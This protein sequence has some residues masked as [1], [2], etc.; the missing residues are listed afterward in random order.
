ME[1]PMSLS[2]LAAIGS[3]VSGVA[4]LI[5]LIYLALQIRQAA[6]NQRGT[7]HQMRA[8]LSTDVM[9][10]IAEPE[11]LPAFRAGLTGSPDISEAQFWQYY[12]AASAILRATE[13][14]FA[15][16]RDGLVSETHF[17]S[18]KASARSFLSY[19]GYR[20]LWQASRLGREAGFRDFMDSLEREVSVRPPP[21]LYQDWKSRLKDAAVQNEKAGLARS[22]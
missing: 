8:A 2:D 5:S 14:A 22:G 1:I 4:V 6:A 13:N 12:Y 20:A 19:P 18:A 15:Q 7:M 9:L 11:L 3:F 16:Y 10:R 17:A 21:E